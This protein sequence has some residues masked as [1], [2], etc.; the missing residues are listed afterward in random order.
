MEKLAKKLSSQLDQVQRERMELQSEYQS[1]QRVIEDY[2]KE[3]SDLKGELKNM[4][5]VIA[6]T[7]EDEL[8][9]N[10]HLHAD[11]SQISRLGNW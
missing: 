10:G 11:K 4:K 6:H 3:L 5:N 9:T 8:K 7:F 2:N 1:N